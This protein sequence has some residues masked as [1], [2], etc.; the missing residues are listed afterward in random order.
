MSFRSDQSRLS[1]LWLTSGT[2]TVLGIALNLL[3]PLLL[4]PTVLAP[5]GRTKQSANQAPRCELGAWR[6]T[7]LV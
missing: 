6:S 1:P 2:G 5:A 4:G 3:A 7:R